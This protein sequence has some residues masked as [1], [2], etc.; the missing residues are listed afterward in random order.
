MAPPLQEA[1]RV[2]DRAARALLE[3][4]N[5][6]AEWQWNQP[7]AEGKWSS[8]Q[9]L[10]HLIA[11]YDVVLRELGGGSGMRVRTALWQRLL[12]RATILPRIM[13]GGGFPK[14]APAPREL[15]P[16]EGV[17]RSRGLALFEERAK[18]FEIAAKNADPRQRVTHA[19]FGSSS[20][21]NGVLLCARHI[22]HHTAQIPK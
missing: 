6:V 11:T 16:E 12:L 22:E 19:Y 15:R 1:L 9:I 14:R 17:E 7:V 18:Q 20:V 13:R 5:G 10:E 21:A 2:H 8:A 4:A 3:A